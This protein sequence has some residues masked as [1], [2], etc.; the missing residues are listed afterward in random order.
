MPWSATQQKRLGFEKNLLE[1]YFRNRVTWIDPTGN[2]RV[3]VRVTCT[4]DKQ[5]TLRVYL[6]SDYP[7]SCPEMIV[8]Y[9][10]SCLRRRDGSL[11]SGMSGADHILGLRDGCTKICHFDSSLWKDDN[12][13]YQIV[14][15]GLIWLEAYEAHLRTGHSLNR[16]LQEMWVEHFIQQLWKP[17]NT[18]VRW[19]YSVNWITFAFVI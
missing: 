10:S 8:S 17:D 3:E 11:M 2:T 5:Y 13:L 14:M 16:Y 12:T 6:P 7:S 9:P 4:N 1:K 19:D 15:K 18:F